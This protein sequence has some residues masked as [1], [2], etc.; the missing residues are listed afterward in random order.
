MNI[1]K[2]IVLII[3]YVSCYVVYYLNL[4]NLIEFFTNHIKKPND[5]IYS[6]KFKK[7]LIAVMILFTAIYYGFIYVI[8]NFIINHM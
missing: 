2:I 1:Y 7:K 4:D 5:N 3:L 6:N 8:G